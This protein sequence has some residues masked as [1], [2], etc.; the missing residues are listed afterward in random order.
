MYKRIGILKKI[1]FGEP[2]A[3]GI[4][5]P[6][7]PGPPGFIL[8]KGS[9]EDGEEIPPHFAAQKGEPGEPGPKVS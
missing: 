8:H 5:I 9:G 2:G 4:G 6:G 1:R 7:P 3:P